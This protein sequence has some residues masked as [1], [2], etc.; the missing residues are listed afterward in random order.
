MTL[1]VFFT[2]VST[3]AIG[4][5]PGTLSHPFHVSLAEV[6]YNPESKSLEIALKVWPEDLE[7]ALQRMEK[8]KI[9]LDGRKDLDRL[10]ERYVKRNIYVSEDGKKI[11]EIQWIG[12]EIGI[13]EAWLYFEIPTGQPPVG[14]RFKNTLFFELQDDQVNIFQFKIDGKRATLNFTRD[15][16]MIRL[17]PDKLVSPKK[18]RLGDR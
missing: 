17:E 9:D 16:S 1:V 12:Q 18:Q 2:I 11:N 10:I 3:A 15:R 14:F 6:E 4:A 13:K 5:D 7:K 8:K